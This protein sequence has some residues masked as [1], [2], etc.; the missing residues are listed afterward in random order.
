MKKLINGIQRYKHRLAT[1]ALIFGFLVDLIT[2]RSLNLTIALIILS[3]HICIVAGTIIVLS[4]PFEERDSFF[5]KVRSWL[6]VLQQYSMGNL[7]SAFL[8]LYSASGSIA[9]SWPFLVLVALAAIGNEALK[10]KRYRLLF[11]TTLFFLNLML[12]VALLLPVLF[13]SINTLTFVVSMVV[14][15]AVFA[16]FRKALYMVAKDSY[17]EHRVGIKRAGIVALTV[18]V[19]LYVTNLIPP[20]PL[21][22]KDIDFYYEVNRV[23]D[24]YHV[25]EEKDGFLARYFDFAGDELR[26]TAGGAA[27]VY[28][29]VFAPAKINTDVVH[30]WEYYNTEK[31]SWVTK[32]TVHFPIVGGRSGGYRGYSFT[33]Q[34]EPG[35]WRV[36][37]ET[38]SGKVIGRARLNIVQTDMPVATETTILQ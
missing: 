3:V 26:L 28:T 30:R 4:A 7:L 10:L 24:T 13:G 32:N 31:N 9:Q 20:I 6:P 15:V 19:A 17:E 18:M 11:Q 34:P 36:S 25:R 2:F 35:V 37:V 14:A 12:Y 21:A 27:Y 23:G 22:L 29:A 8:I 5:T 33:T 1:V 16:L 38:T